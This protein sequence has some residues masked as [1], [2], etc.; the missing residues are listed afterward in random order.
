MNLLPSRKCH[1]LSDALMTMFSTN[2]AEISVSFWKQSWQCHQAIGRYLSLLTQRLGRQIWPG[3]S[4]WLR[5]SSK[6]TPEQQSQQKRCGGS[7]TSSRKS[8][9][10]AGSSSSRTTTFWRVP[11][12]CLISYRTP[13]LSM[14]KSAW[15]LSSTSCNIGP[16]RSRQRTSSPA[17]CSPQGRIL[18]KSLILKAMF[19]MYRYSVS[20]LTTTS[21]PL[22]PVYWIRI[23][24]QGSSGYGFRIWIQ[25]Y[26]KI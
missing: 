14:T 24:I 13:G 7:S 16:S 5:G 23:Q 10:Q 15:T 12:F 20:P 21:A 6:C 22:P 17:C 18:N 3:G 19:N 26:L 11:G 1:H 8:M 2:S 25:G 4:R 9:L